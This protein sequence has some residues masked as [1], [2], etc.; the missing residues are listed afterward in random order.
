[1]IILAAIITGLLMVLFEMLA[2]NLALVSLFP[3][4]PTIS[5][6]QML[7]IHT[8]FSFLFGQVKVK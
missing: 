4:I 1:M 2:W 3:I 5:Y 7:G 6:W 8:L